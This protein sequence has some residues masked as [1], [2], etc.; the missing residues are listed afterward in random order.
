MKFRRAT[1]L[2][3]CC[4]AVCGGARGQAQTARPGAPPS[5]P[6]LISPPAPG[7]TL[8]QVRLT[9]DFDARTFTG[10]SRVRW[11]NRDARPASVVYFNLYANVRGN[12]VEPATQ[13]PS[14]AASPA[15][16]EDEPRIEIK[17]VRARAAS[18]PAVAAA[19]QQFALEERATVLR[20]SL[21]DAVAPDAAAEIE[22][23]FAGSVPELDADETSLPAH[24]IQQLGAALRDTREMRGARDTNFLARGVMLLGASYPVMAVREGAEWRRGARAGVGDLIYA[25]AADY[26]FEVE[27]AR[28][29]AVFTSGEPHGGAAVV[30]G[31]ANPPVPRTFVGN[32]LRGFAVVA[33]RNLRSAVRDVGK[34]RVQSVFSREH[35]K[36]GRRVLD[37]AARAVE[38]F[39]ARF[40]PAPY[41]LMTIAE[42]PFSAG[43]GSAEFTGL[44]AIA[45]AYYVDFDSPAVRNLPELVREQRTSVE[46]SLEFAVA[47]MIA[48]QWWGGAVGS[49]PAREPVLDEALAHWSALVYYREAH[50]AERAAQA[51]EDQLEGVYEIYR[52]FGG[53]DLP[54]DRAAR[55]YRNSF[56]YAAVV[57]AKGALAF[58]A[59]EKL[60][61][62]ERVFRALRGYHEANRFEIAELD[63]LRAAL[64]SEANVSERRA[65]TRTLA[66][67][68][69]QR[70]GD[71]DISPPNAQLA[72]D[73]GLSSERGPAAPNNGNRFSRLGKFFWRQMTRIR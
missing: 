10:T 12:V 24:V 39:S 47:H 34:V 64:V 58:A 73:L 2:L 4:A 5:R 72:S 14:A 7:R 32:N 31:D 52:T 8:Y 3:L 9:L 23:D 56:Q 20:V 13:P 26:E 38:I 11:T 1:L 69:S 18:S 59:V 40:G 36:T 29:V 22:I 60:L 46:D 66:R 19:P 71:E 42:A 49:D 17:A 16:I 37:V 57:A 65:V 62:A 30:S 41:P 50:G 53:E 63:D 44:C 35:E 25:E 51:S 48:H 55:E 45:S 28:G 21:R 15:P 27:T 67:W 61:G 68:L 6:Q 33:G 54:A 43:V 70:H